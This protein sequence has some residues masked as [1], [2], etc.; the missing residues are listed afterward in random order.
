M[1]MMMT[2]VSFE[3]DD[4]NAHHDDDGQHTTARTNMRIIKYILVVSTMIE[5][6]GENGDYDDTNGR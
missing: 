6:D 2:V 5:L 4:N 3:D 1:T